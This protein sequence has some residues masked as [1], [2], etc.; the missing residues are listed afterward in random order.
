MNNRLIINFLR[1]VGLLLL[2]VLVVDDIRLG[3]YIHPCVYVLFVFLLPFN[4]PNWQLLF[5]GFAMGIAVDLF[6]GTPGLNAAATVFMAFIRPFVIS[7]MTRRNDINENEEPSLEN[8]GT[9]RFIVYS[10]FLLLA[11]NLL[12]FILEAFSFKLFGIVLLQ[13]LLS[14][15]SSILLIFI[16]L[17]LFK[18]NKKKLI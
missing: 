4:T 15:F 1:F 3:Y 13:T 12:L 17:L 9:G 5:S 10:L 14:V 8:M 16:I 18:K 6:N 7:G 2:Q 11:H